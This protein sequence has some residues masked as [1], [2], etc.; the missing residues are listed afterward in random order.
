MLTDKR[1][2]SRAPLLKAG[3]GLAML[4]VFG[5]AAFH[6]RAASRV[7]VSLTPPGG[8]SPTNTPQMVLVTFDDAVTAYTFDIVQEMLANRYNPN[9][10]P[11][12][13]TFFVS[14][15]WTDY[16]LAH[17][18]YCA[19]HEIAIHT[20]THTTSDETALSVWRAEIVGCRRTLARLAAIPQED[21]RGFRAPFLEFNGESFQ[22]LHEQGLTYDTSIT[23]QPGVLSESIGRMIW[24]YTLDNGVQ[25]NC[26]TGVPPSMP[27][28]G[29][30]E[31]PLWSLYDPSTK[32]WTPMDPAGDAAA[33]M[34]TLQ[35]NFLARYNGNRAPL[36][37]FMHA[38]G[39]AGKSQYIRNFIEW[40]QLFPHVWFVNLS[41]AAAFMQTPKSVAEAHTFPAFVTVLRTP[42]PESETRS[43]NFS[44]GTVRTCGEVPLAYPC[45]NTVYLVR[46]SRPGG[47]MSFELTSQWETGY[48][49][50]LTIRNDT[51]QQ[52]DSWQAAFEL[53][54]CSVTWMTGASRQQEVDRMTLSPNDSGVLAPGESVSVVFGGNRT[55]EVQPINVSVTLISTSLKRPRIST[56]QTGMDSTVRLAWDDSAFGYAVQQATNSLGQG[57]RTVQEVHG[58]TNWTGMVPESERAIFYRLQT[59]P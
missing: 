16:W 45:T 6:V 18:L 26:W 12:Q 8:L 36:G 1:K 41:A 3:T 35:T 33:V 37:I 24:P 52:A 13:A 9:G 55:Q 48:G 54:G 40:A 49:A 32:G 20:M 56:I 31:I 25:Q 42:V 19:G 28:P 2:L 30:F 38:G 17:R 27:L 59:V 4:L 34:A 53:P 50:R 11:I 51:A 29:L 7:D 43:V 14:N 47:S 39:W 58:A 23:E 21:I 5:L 44:K 57:W 15:D 46:E 22:I 10:T